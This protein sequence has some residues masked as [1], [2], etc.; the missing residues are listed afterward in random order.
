MGKGSEALESLSA[1]VLTAEEAEERRAAAE[2]GGEVE[3]TTDGRLVKPVPGAP[4][5]V[6]EVAQA[7]SATWD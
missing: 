1:Q 7:P 2:G 6:R 5:Q 4:E 3:A